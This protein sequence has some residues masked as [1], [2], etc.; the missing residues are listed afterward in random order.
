M[1]AKGRFITLE[2]GE[3]VGKSTLAASLASRLGE[4]GLKHCSHAG[5]RRLARRRG[6]SAPDPD[7]AAGTRPMGLAHR[8]ADVL[9][10]AARPSRQADPPGARGRQL[11]H[12]RPVLGLTRAP[13]RRR[14]AAWCVTRSKRWSGSS[15]DPAGPDLTLILDLPVSIARARMTARAIADD[16]IESRGPEYHERVRQAFLDI[17]RALPKRCAVID[18]SMAA[19]LVADAA[20]KIIDQRLSSSALG[21]A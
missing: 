8:S 13:T 10:G 16:A 1:A 15:S 3:G 7:P 6:A 17:A 18:A 19:E 2:G 12:L 4:R 20:M 14:P 5:A 11:G 21:D 9:C